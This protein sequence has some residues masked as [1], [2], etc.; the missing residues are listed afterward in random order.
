MECQIVAIQKF[1]WRCCRAVLSLWCSVNATSMTTKDLIVIFEWNFTQGV[2]NQMH[3][4][5]SPIGCASFCL[6]GYQL[7]PSLTADEWSTTLKENQIKNTSNCAFN[8]LFIKLLENC[9]NRDSL[10][11]TS[12]IHWS[13]VPESGDK[14]LQRIYKSMWWSRLY[15]WLHSAATL[16]FKKRLIK[17]IRSLDG[18]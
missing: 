11:A 13:E 18:V 7:G 5:S 4:F 15:S 10:W 2:K 1:I 9:W 6:Q 17:V 8:I 16:Q 14:T 3:D 12:L